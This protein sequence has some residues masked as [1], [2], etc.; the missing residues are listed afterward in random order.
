MMTNSFGLPATSAGAAASDKVG[1]SPVS[2]TRDMFTKLLVA[3]IR[4]QDP[5]S[6]SDPSQFVNQL[7]QLSQTESLQ[8]LAQTQSASASLLQNLQ[9]LAMG[10]QVGSDITVA[11]GSVRVGEQPIAGTVQLTAGSSAT[12]LTLT[13]ADGQEHKLSLPA[14]GAGTLA[15]TI[16]PAALGLAPGSYSISAQAADGTRPSVEVNGR[17]ESV[18][19]SG[20][21]GVVL[22]VANIGEVDPSA[23]TG[24]NGKASTQVAALP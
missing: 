17:I 1:S 18:R 14:H 10:A 16:D 22:Q 12:T 24:F 13:G 8:G 23:V 7:A 20:T 9:V 19:M 3:Q 5:L 15:F 11:T 21:G 6:P 2:E 4:N